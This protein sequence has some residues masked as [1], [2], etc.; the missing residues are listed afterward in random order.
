MRAWAAIEAAAT[1][2]AAASAEIPAS[3]A[4]GGEADCMVLV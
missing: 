3:G 4:I 1:S 2:G